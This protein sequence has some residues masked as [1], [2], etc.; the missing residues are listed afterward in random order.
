MQKITVGFVI[1]TYDD[2]GKC[3]AA[4]F[5]AGDQVDWEDGDGEAIDPPAH[6][7]FPFSML[8]P[9]GKDEAQ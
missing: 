1:Q 8:Q 9:N 2:A 6:E 5:V 7:Y 3:T 4:E